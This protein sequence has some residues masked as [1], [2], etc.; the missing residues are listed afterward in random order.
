MPSELTKLQ[1]GILIAAVVVN[2]VLAFLVISKNR[3]SE[4]HLSFFLFIL[5]ISGWILSIYFLQQVANVFWGKMGFVFGSLMPGSFLWFAIVF[6]EIEKK[7]NK[8]WIILAFLIPFIFTILPSDYLFQ[9]QRIEAGSIVADNGPLLPYF[10]IICVIFALIGLYIIVKDY[11]SAKGIARVQFQFVLWGLIF[12]TITAMS[13]NVILPALGIYTFNGIGPVFSII[14]IGAITYAILKRHL[15]DIKVIAT[16]ALVFLLV[17]ISIIQFFLSENLS[18]YIINGFILVALIYVGYLLIQSVRHEIERRK[19]LQELTAELRAA[20]KKL[21]ELD[22]LKTEFVSIASHELLTP[23][24][25]IQGYLSM[26]LD[27]KILPMDDPKTEE[28]LKKVHGSSDR[29]ARLVTDLL[30]VSRIESG[31][32]VM[33]KQK[34]DINQVIKIATGELKVKT[35]EKNLELLWSPQVQP[36]VYADKDR[37]KQVLINVVGNAIKFTEKGKVEISTEFVKNK[38][39]GIKLEGTGDRAKRTPVRGDFVIIHVKDTGIGIPKEELSNIFK[40]FHRI[41][42]W[43]TR[44]TGG[45]GLG[46][47]IAKNILELLGGKI[48]AESEYGKGSIFSFSVPLAQNADPRGQDA[49][50]RGFTYNANL[51]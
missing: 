43:Q 41:G 1:E 40:K 42:D 51:R 20:N 14:L 29:L 44:S 5:L 30:N 19:K 7:A 34:F 32:I 11:L 47:F 46:L 31:R 48:W 22:A 18:E 6:P 36:K 33:E 35:A 3:K 49:D 12:F 38:E 39:L 9:N 10:S 27:E 25:A 15:L 21:A 28:I 50:K 17:I 2:L 23:I 37:M 16:E 4:L 24:S 13:S 26:I 8:L 45:T